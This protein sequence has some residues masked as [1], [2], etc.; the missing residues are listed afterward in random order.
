M[1]RFDNMNLLASIPSYKL[2]TPSDHDIHGHLYQD[3]HCLSKAMVKQVPLSWWFT[4]TS[5]KTD[6]PAPK[7]RSTAKGPTWQIRQ[8]QN[9]AGRSIRWAAHS[10][11]ALNCKQSI[12]PTHLVYHCEFE[13]PGNLHGYANE[14]HRSQTC[15]KCV[16]GKAVISLFR[17]SNP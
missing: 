13:R 3:N 1:R 4:T 6:S 2:P 7:A 15:R 11:L 16:Q 5:M 12:C 8:L 17:C 10:G 9:Q 14:H